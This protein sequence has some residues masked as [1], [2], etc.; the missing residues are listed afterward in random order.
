MNSA[1]KSAKTVSNTK[2]WDAYGWTYNMKRL[3]D[4]TMIGHQLMI[5]NVEKAHRDVVSFK[6]RK[7]RLE[8][9]L[10]V[11]RLKHI[12]ILKRRT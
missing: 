2:R 3:V 12:G 5:S 10:Y 7:A 8:L 4:G 9:R 1:S 6:L 11:A